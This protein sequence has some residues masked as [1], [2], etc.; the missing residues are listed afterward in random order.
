MTLKMH[1]HDNIVCKEKNTQATSFIM[2][3]VAQIQCNCAQ[4]NMNNKQ[5]SYNSLGCFPISS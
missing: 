2:E 4:V 1:T 3:I 5:F